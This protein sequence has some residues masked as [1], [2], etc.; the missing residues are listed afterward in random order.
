M[1]NYLGWRE[2]KKVI[3]LREAMTIIQD[4]AINLSGFFHLNSLDRSILNRRGIW[5]VLL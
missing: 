1:I 4:I 2:R 3:V 5:L